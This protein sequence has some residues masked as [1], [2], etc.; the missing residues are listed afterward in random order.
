VQ[1]DLIP[2]G[3]HLNAEVRIVCEKWKPSAGASA[4]NHPGVGADTGSLSKK[5]RPVTQ[6][7]SHYSGVEAGEEFD[8]INE[9]LG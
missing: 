9:R 6:I 1:I 3:R 4:G 8:L 7:A 2:D 5:N